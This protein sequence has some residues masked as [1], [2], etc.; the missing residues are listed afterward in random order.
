VTSTTPTYSISGRIATAAGVGIASVNVTRTGSTTPAVTNTNGDFS[1]T[2]LAAGTYTLTP[3]RSGYVFTPLTRAAT[4]TTANVT[5]QNFTGA[6]I[7]TVTGFTPTS[8]PVGTSVVITGTNF[9]GTTVVKF[10]T[11]NATSFT[12]NSAT[13]IT[14]AV[15]TGA[16]MG[17]ISVT[18]PGGT[19]LSAGTFTVTVV[20]TP[21]FVDNFADA[22]FITGVSGT[23]TGSNV[24]M[25]LEA[26]EP[27]IDGN[28][29]GASV[30][31]KWVAP[32]SGNF[33]FTTAGSSFDTLMA[34]ATGTSL[35]T[36]QGFGND[37]EV[38]GSIFT[39]RVDFAATAGVTYYF[40]IDGFDGET[41]PIKLSW[42]QF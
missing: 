22:K 33:T 36:L 37:D 40:V 8:G 7:P 21:A 5:A 28:P 34:V 10:N 23:L 11:T 39:S 15:P 18:T 3:A 29:G 26:G 16:T 17:K 31:V 32:V 2:G 27:T 35:A 25:T 9:T 38:P 1:F 4:I 42:S 30:W 14:A 24:G 20:N 6:P 41:G 13:Q 12:V 19:A